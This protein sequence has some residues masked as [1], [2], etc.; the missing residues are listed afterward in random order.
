MKIVSWNANC[1][2]RDKLNIIDACGW[3]VLV[4]QECENPNTSKDSEYKMWATNYK[5]VGDLEY[6]GLGLFLSKNIN[7]E[8]IGI[9]PHS[10]KHFIT[11]QL[12][13]GMQILAVWAHAGSKRSVGYI[14]QLWEYLKANEKTLDWDNLVI[15]GDWNS[16]AQWDKK[17][18]VGNHSDVC[19]FLNSKGL[20]SGYHSDGEIPHGNEPD[21][22]FFMHRNLDK[23][24]HIDYLFAAP[25][26]LSNSEKMNIGNPNHWLLYSDHLP[27]SYRLTMDKVL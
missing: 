10:N 17:R 23:G 8:I 27:I 13:N 4:V 12:P 26:F 18:K 21:N 11:V 6:K 19:K 1:K 7:A 14:Y 22:T 15:I 3:D 25:K 16:N 20:F 5:W 2:F 9:N 24:H